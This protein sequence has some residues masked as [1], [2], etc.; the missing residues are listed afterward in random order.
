MSNG[1]DD[2]R[3]YQ[4]G[5][6]ETLVDE[7]EVHTHPVETD[8]LANKHLARMMKSRHHSA[9]LMRYGF[10]LAGLALYTQAYLIYTGRPGQA[11]TTFIG[12]LAVAL[13]GLATLHIVLSYY[14]QWRAGDPDATTRRATRKVI[15]E[16]PSDSAADPE[17]GPADDTGHDHDD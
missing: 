14:H 12:P 2:P 4:P 10:L 7:R 5:E 16:Y 17:S 3:P 15:Y 8:D 1:G 13:G 6:N 11:I 9:K